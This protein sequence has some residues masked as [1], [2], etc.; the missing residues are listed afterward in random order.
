MDTI[1]IKADVDPHDINIC[2][3]TVD[4][5]VHSGTVVFNSKKEAAENGLAE[6]LFNIPDITKVELSE[7]IVIVTKANN[8]DWRQ[9]GRRIGGSIRSFLQP[10]PDIP[11]ADL[12]PP[13]VL[14]ERVQQF[15][16]RQ[17]NPMVASHGGYVEL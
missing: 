4:R 17:I 7:N 11:E 14:R 5:P 15:P 13:A 12:L 8:E 6:K 10:A 3:F 2:K 9:V 1:R 16:E